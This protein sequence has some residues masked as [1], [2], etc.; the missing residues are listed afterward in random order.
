MRMSNFVLRE[1]IVPRLKARTKDAVIREMVASLVRAGQFREEETEEVVQ[2]VLRRE[3][4]GS[5]GI[6]RNIA[7]PHA[8]HVGVT[9]LVGT[10]AL[11]DEGI[12]FESIDGEA[13]HV[14]VLLVSPNNK[15]GEHL[16]ALESVVRTMKD[17]KF[18]LDL[19]KASTVDEIWA[20]LEGGRS[21]T[22]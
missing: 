4:L 22:P 6:G 13:V 10:L 12:P 7:I 8:K 5:T 9:Q 17:D 2:G 11:S 1:A 14:L 3:A 15:P 16:R 19:R 20:L 18:I 21:D